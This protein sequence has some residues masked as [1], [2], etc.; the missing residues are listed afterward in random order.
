MTRYLID[1]SI[2]DT[3]EIEADS[4]EEAAHKFAQLSNLDL[5]SAIDTREVLEGPNTEEDRRT[6]AEMNAIAWEKWKAL[7]TQREAARS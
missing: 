4:P 7:Q 5:V 3:T 1:W 2:S 6:E